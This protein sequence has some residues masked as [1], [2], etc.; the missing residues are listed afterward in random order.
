M[1]PGHLKTEVAVRH[2]DA[3]GGDIR[4]TQHEEDRMR[5]IHIG[6]RGSEAASEEQPD[7]LRKTVRFEQEA[8]K[9][10]ASSDPTVALEYPASGETQDRPGS[11]LVQKS[12]LVDDDVQIA[13]LDLFYEMDGRKSRYIGEVLE[14]YRGED[15]GDLKKNELNE[16]VENLTCPNAPEVKIWK[17]NQ[18][19]VMDEQLVQK[20]VMDEDL[21]QNG[22]MDGKCV[23]NFLV[24]AKIDAKVVMD[25]STFKIVGW[26]SL[27]TF[28]IKN[29]WRNILMRMNRGS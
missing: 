4:E 16:L 28:L 20:D 14:W 9:A 29:C 11:V 17:S 26:N 12:G 2:T 3:S 7:K 19:V 25:L 27:A 6:K 13:A 10:S 23:K 21:V 15:A 5:D 1:C 22:V 8:S 24:D 18:K